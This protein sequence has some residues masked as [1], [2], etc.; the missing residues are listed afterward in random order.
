MGY[1]DPVDRDLDVL[2][3]HGDLAVAA[4]LCHATLLADPSSAMDNSS[5]I[6]CIPSLC[7]NEPHVCE[8][9]MFG[10]T[11]DDIAARYVPT[12]IAKAPSRLVCNCCWISCAR[13]WR[14]Q[15]DIINKKKVVSS[16]RES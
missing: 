5:A 13:S 14:R 10:D 2:D 11:V 16:S 1:A 7:Y 15:L 3:R 8:H 12:S 6:Y 9:R 4:M